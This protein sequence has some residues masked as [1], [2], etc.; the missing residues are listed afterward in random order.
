MNIAVCLRTLGRDTRQ[1]NRVLINHMTQKDFCKT[2]M[3]S[4]TPSSILGG[5][6][7]RQSLI[8]SILDEIIT[9]PKAFVKAKPHILLKLL[10]SLIIRM[11]DQNWF[12]R[13]HQIDVFISKL[14]SHIPFIFLVIPYNVSVRSSKCLDSLTK[15]SPGSQRSKSVPKQQEVEF[16]TV[17]ETFPGIIPAPESPKVY[18]QL[19]N[20]QT[21]GIEYGASFR[22]KFLKRK[23]SFLPYLT[24]KSS[25]PQ[26]VGE[27]FD[28]FVHSKELLRKCNVTKDKVVGSPMLLRGEG[29][30]CSMPSSPVRQVYNKILGP[31][32]QH[33]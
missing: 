31:L 20:L 21:E 9:K 24:K 15:H 1:S 6:L 4:Y 13:H 12:K 28:P 26:V 23:D 30:L 19:T 29:H 32:R 18:G 16:K 7:R 22:T 3:K 8:N 2:K 14:Q 27:Q 33:S 11:F 5:K 17:T 10:T 25:M